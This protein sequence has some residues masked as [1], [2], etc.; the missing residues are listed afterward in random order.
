MNFKKD[1]PILSSDIIYLDNAATTLKPLGVVEEIKNYYIN[2]PANAHRGDYKISQIVDDK[3]DEV[4][5]K[6][7]KF[8][9]AEKEKE[10]IFTSG[11][12][13]SIN[14]VINGFFEDYLNSGDEVLTTKAEHASLILPWFNLAKKLNLNIGNITSTYNKCNSRYKTN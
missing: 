11:T 7:K 13:E 9:N 5:N 1:F 14:M 12:T 4:R 10:I 6:V 2:Y 8:I 3:I